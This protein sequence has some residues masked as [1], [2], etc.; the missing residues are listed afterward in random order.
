MIVSMILKKDEII[1]CDVCSIELHEGDKVNMELDYFCE[2]AEKKCC[3][4]CLEDD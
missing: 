2:Y 4:S 3:E 1:W